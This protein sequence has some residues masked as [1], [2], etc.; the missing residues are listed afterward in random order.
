MVNISS[1][2]NVYS[3]QICLDKKKLS[4]LRNSYLVIRKTQLQLNKVYC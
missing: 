2:N 3:I 1:T 4:M